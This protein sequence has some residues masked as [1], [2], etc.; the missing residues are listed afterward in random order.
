M[1]IEAVP[2]DRLRGVLSQTRVPVLVRRGK[3]Y[4]LLMR[5]PYSLTNRGWL[6][7]S[8]TRDPSWDDVRKQWELPQAWFG[9]LVKRGLETYGAL[10][11]VQPYREQE[12]CAPACWDAEGDECQCSC[13]GVNHGSRSTN[14]KWRVISDAFATRWGERELACRLLMAAE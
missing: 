7:I 11:V 5:L 10:Y 12:K 4:P 2:S 6:R 1:S 14:G 3:G 9:D 8:G 13:M